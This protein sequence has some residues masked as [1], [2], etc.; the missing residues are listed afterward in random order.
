MRTTAGSVLVDYLEDVPESGLKRDENAMIGMVCP[1][2][3]PQLPDPTAPTS[4]VG[5]A[6]MQEIKSLAPW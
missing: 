2:D 6:L 3:L 4:A 1:I 5:Q